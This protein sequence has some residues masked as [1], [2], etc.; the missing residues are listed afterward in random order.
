MHFAGK[1]LFGASV[2][3]GALLGPVTEA[4][5]ASAIEQVWVAP[6]SPQWTEDTLLLDHPQSWSA[7]FD[8]DV[9]V[10]GHRDQ[11]YTYGTNV[12][13]SGANVKHH[14]LSLHA[15][16]HR[17]DTALGIATGHGARRIEYGL[18]GFTPENIR[19][20]DADTNDRPYASLVYVASTN[21]YYDFDNNSAWN[22]TLTIGAL[23]LSAV[24]EVQKGV[25]TAIDGDKPQGW[26]HQISE[27]GE[28][29]LRLSIARQQLLSDSSDVY[30]MKS[31]VQI[32]LGY[33]TEVNLSIGGRLGRLRTPW[34]SFTPELASYGEKSSPATKSRIF[35]HYLWGG[36]TLKA[37]A[38]NAFL[39]G[40]FRDSEVEYSANDL[41]HGIVE[42]WLGYTFSFENGYRLSYA[43]RGH[44]SEIKHGQAD[45]NV[46]WGG[47]QLAK[48][49]GA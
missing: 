32:S 41:H 46:L 4:Q 10:P 6:A 40:Q 17:L 22:S 28:P 2:I 26:Q 31:S 25:H 7:T 33:I 37:R 44:S 30:E 43:I 21:E 27:G 18:F 49:F 14:W 1:A 36:L 12:H 39:Q 24:G 35:E 38:Y 11:D 34:L 48:T 19:N 3:F 15:P 20:S 47:I 42:A 5:A 9:L 16:L 23:G 8:N 29:T 45:R 13:F